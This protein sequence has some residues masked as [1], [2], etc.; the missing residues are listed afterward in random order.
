M[1]K[2]KKIIVP[3]LVVLCIPLFLAGCGSKEAFADSAQNK[4][5]EIWFALNGNT[6]E[7]ILYVQK[8]TI[9]S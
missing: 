7:N 2:F 8:N 3:L 9:T 1:K 6:V 5:G 4:N